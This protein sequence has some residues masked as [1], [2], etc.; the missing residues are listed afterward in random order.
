[1]T[2]TATRMIT[3]RAEPQVAEGYRTVATSGLQVGETVML[4]DE[5]DALHEAVVVHQITKPN[6]QGV[7][8][9]LLM[10]TDE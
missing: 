9:W 2:I 5:N 10:Y 8:M 3:E 7:A 6:S 4:P 1:M